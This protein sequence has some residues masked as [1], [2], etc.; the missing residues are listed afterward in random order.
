MVHHLWGWSTTSAFSFQGPLFGSDTMSENLRGPVNTALEATHGPVRPESGRQLPPGRATQE[1]RALSLILDEDWAGLPEAQHATLEGCTDS[2]VLLE[3]L[4]ADG[5]LTTY[6]AA[7]LK[8]GKFAG[9]VLG[10]YRVL[11]RVGTGAMGIV[12]K[13]EHVRMRHTVAIKVLSWDT[14]QEPQLLARFY[15]EMRAV[16]RLHHPNI[17]AAIDAGET[18]GEPDE[19]ALHYFVMEYVQGQNLEEYVRANG[20]LPP[21]RACQIIYQIATALEEAHKHNLVHRDI[22]PSN[23]LLTA[24]DQAKLLDFGLAMH[25]RSRMT[26]PGTLLGTI[27]FMAPEQA[28]DASSVDVRAD[29]YS[30]GS[31]FYWCLTG[32]S[33]FPPQDNFLQDVL[34]RMTQA[35]AVAAHATAR[36]PARAGRITG[37]HDGPSAR[38]PLSHA[39]SRN[40][41][42]AALHTSA[43][44][45]LHHARTSLQQ[46]VPGRSSGPSASGSGPGSTHRVLVVDDEEAIRT[47]CQ[48][49]L[50][51]ATL[52][53]D[54]AAGGAAALQMLASQPCDLV[55]LDVNMPGMTGLELVRRL[56]ASPPSANLKI[57]MFSGHMQGDEM[58][59]LA[60]CR[61]G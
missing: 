51:D 5:L 25:F 58:A 30:L 60:S 17:V 23:I 56:R 18:Q 2:A 53:C 6:Q 38:R 3:L 45:W 31:T 24:D 20:P 59:R 47:I 4:A 14:H 22:K 21:A 8:V 12:Y 43:T 9:L 57:V 44:P 42:P 29:I 33:P 50:Q 32:Q 55:L 35:G 41:G 1:I 54:L 28:S 36:P 27:D 37:A 34:A 46:L 11:D 61:R 15:A 49:F 7:R 10:N 16:A 13:A 39:A 52:E 19:P 26:L 40:P 48:S